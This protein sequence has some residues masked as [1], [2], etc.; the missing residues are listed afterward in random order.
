M[1]YTSKPLSSVKY[2]TQY[3]VSN[4][5]LYAKT[6]FVHGIIYRW[7]YEIILVNLLSSLYCFVFPAVLPLL[8]VF[9]FMFSNFAGIFFSLF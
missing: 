2:L 5:P 6:I 4:P 8:F 9:D 7:V 3:E 1:A